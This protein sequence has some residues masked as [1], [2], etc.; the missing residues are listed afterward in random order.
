MPRRCAPLS[1]RRS[2]HRR[3]W[4][5]CGAPTHGATDLAAAERTLAEIEIECGAQEPA[6]ILLRRRVVEALLGECQQR[7]A[8]E[9]E[10]TFGDADALRSPLQTIGVEPLG[11]DRLAGD[12]VVRQ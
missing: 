8:R 7:T 1:R 5:A 11:L 6:R 2:R 10:L 12:R 4:R 3:S 9:H